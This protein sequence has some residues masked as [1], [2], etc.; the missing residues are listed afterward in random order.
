MNILRKF[1][2][3]LPLQLITMILVIFLAGDHIPVGIKEFFYTISVLIKDLL[4]LAL[5]YIIFAYLFSTLVALQNGAILFVISLVSC[6]VFM[7]FMGLNIAYFA[8]SLLTEMSGLAPV[9][10][11]PSRELMAMWKLPVPEFIKAILKNEH[12]L[13]LGVLSG[14]GL[15]YLKVTGLKEISDRLKS[16]AAFI[17]NKMF[18][19]VVPFFILGFI[20]KMEH[21]GTLTYVLKQYGPVYLLIA[22]VQVIYLLSLFAIGAKLNP[23]TWL[24]YLRNMLPPVITGVS[25]MSSAAA[26]P[27]SLTAAE[28][29]TKNPLIARSV[30]PATVNM[31][32][33]GDSIGAPLM[34]IATMVTFG[35]GIP[36]YGLFLGFAL[37]YVM[38][39]FT[40]AAV[41]GATILVMTPLIE[42]VLGFNAE[43]VG[44]ATALYILYDAIGTTMNVL[45][46]GAFVV[47][48]NRIFGKMFSG[49]TVEAK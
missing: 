40:V 37:W 7:N 49:K 38:Y 11:D 9:E 24:T 42:K 18:I 4:V 21:E 2:S 46:N 17:L 23:K 8:S 41:P 1:S 14:I 31:N 12:G 25:T 10:S 5:P 15:G 30:I 28:Q 26:L 45:G 39:M 13:I 27:F 34:I 48:F 35:L 22:A 44:L 32:L 29:N 19:P 43:M 3:S 20:L 16:G 47:L 6:V 36:S 33:M